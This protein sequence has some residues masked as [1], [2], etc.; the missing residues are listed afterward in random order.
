V[1]EDGAEDW[2]EDAGDATLQDLRLLRLN[3]VE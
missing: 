2:K 3:D 1:K